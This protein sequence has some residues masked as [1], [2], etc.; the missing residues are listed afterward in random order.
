M[1]ARS[2]FFLLILLFASIK[3]YAKDCTIN[4]NRTNF[5]V[6]HYRLNIYFDT[7]N[8]SLTG[9]VQI[10]A[11]YQS[12]QKLPIQIDAQSPLKIT[13]VTQSGKI[14]KLKQNEDAYMI[15]LDENIQKEDTFTILIQYYGTP[16]T[17]VKPPWDGGM[18]IQKDENNIIWWAIACQGIG[19]S[20]WFPCKDVQDDEPDEGVDLFYTV[21]NKLSAIGNGRLIDTIQRNDNLVTWHWM[22]AAP[23]NLYNITFYIGDYVSWEEKMNGLKGNLNLSYY[24]L[25][26]KL[27]KAKKHFSMVPE[28]IQIFEDWMGPYPFY[29]DGYK[30]VEAP[31]LGMEHQSAVA[32][33]NKF[34]LGYLGSDRS[35]TGVGNLFDFIIVHESGHEWFGNNIS[36]KNSAD[37]WIHEGFTSYSE[38]MYIESKFG[39][40]QSMKYLKGTRALIKNELPLINSKDSCQNENT[41]NYP[42]GAN[43]VHIIRL[44]MNNDN[45]FKILLSK[46]N[47][48][49][50]HQTVDSKEIE[51][52]ISKES[53]LKLDKVFDQYLRTALLPK[54]NIT[55]N[56]NGFIYQWQECVK[57]FDMPVIL[58][59]NGIKQWFY[60]TD[61]PKEH[62]QKDIK[63]ISL[64][65]EFYCDFQL[66]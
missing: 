12:N 7:L 57:G 29:E 64:N 36:M 37:F 65:D 41:D 2:Y 19:A 40:E 38:V 15:Y 21:P 54:L 59:V 17:A 18:V 51:T 14:L 45:A 55:K 1:I 16:R 66:N 13:K 39:K 4:E 28:M 31:Y 48:Q 46:M 56:K 43:L 24:V 33:G 6:L 52:F 49:F 58:K 8:K 10:K 22:V 50:Y 30:L 44:L 35:K 47:Q 9:N 61:I 3:L 27:S 53:N 23:I 62:I 32:Y 34:Q 20:I 63:S 60:P 26:N 25:R 5:D 42:K 11:V